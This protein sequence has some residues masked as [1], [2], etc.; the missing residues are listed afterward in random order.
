MKDFKEVLGLVMIVMMVG[1]FAFGVNL[2]GKHYEIT[3]G[4]DEGVGFKEKKE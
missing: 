3:C 4:E 1:A 2:N